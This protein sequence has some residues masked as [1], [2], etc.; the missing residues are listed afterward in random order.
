MPCVRA[1]LLLFAALLV[2]FSPSAAFAHNGEHH[3]ASGPHEG[4]SI[5]TAERH[6]WSPVCPPGSGHVC[7]CDNL[8]LCDGTTAKPW[9]LPRRIASIHHPIQVAAPVSQPEATSQPSP[10]FPPSLPR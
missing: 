7:G 3:K 8:S 10:Q 9:V 6:Y 5:S 2:G 4:R 1:L